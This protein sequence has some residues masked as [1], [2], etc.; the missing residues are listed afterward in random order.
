MTTQDTKSLLKLVEP[1]MTQ[2]LIDE[3]AIKNYSKSE[4]EDA[5][6]QFY[7]IS[8]REKPPFVWLAS[9][10]QM[11]YAPGFITGYKR[12]QIRVFDLQIRFAEEFRKQAKSQL[13]E[14]SFNSFYHAI[15]NAIP[16][17]EL[18]YLSRLIGTEDEFILGGPQQIQQSP[19]LGQL[20]FE[21]LDSNK[22][23]PKLKMSRHIF[24]KI[25]KNVSWFALEH[26]VGELSPWRNQPFYGNPFADPEMIGR[27][28]W[29]DTPLPPHS[30]PQP[31]IPRGKGIEWTHYL[32]M[33]LAFAMFCRTYLNMTLGP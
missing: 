27:I 8:Q 10:W 5:V 21:R 9:P 15:Q 6:G 24:E 16:L 11:H 29:D 2:L 12:E 7:Q 20:L 3:C 13:G 23:P 31:M 18:L 30:D 4:I 28:Q 19:K 1:F 17:R 26:F 32:R 14:Q 25:G 33:H 22:L